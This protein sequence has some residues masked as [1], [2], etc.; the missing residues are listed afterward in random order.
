LI[1]AARCGFL[2]RMRK[3]ALVVMMVTGCAARVV[4]EPAR[5]RD[6]LA[7]LSP[8]ERRA[9]LERAAELEAEQE[10]LDATVAPIQIGGSLTNDASEALVTLFVRLDRPGLFPMLEEQRMKPGQSVKFGPTAVRTEA[11]TATVGGSVIIMGRRHELAQL[12]ANPREPMNLTLNFDTA[13]NQ[14]RLE[15]R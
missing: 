10:R 11:T 14:Y 6:R 3:A 2:H 7:E 5:R 8:E 1:S 12:S 13:L 4:D 15:H 9:V